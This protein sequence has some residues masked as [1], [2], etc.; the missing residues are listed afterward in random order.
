MRRKIVKS[1]YLDTGQGKNS[2]IVCEGKLM[3]HL[4]C[5]SVFFMSLAKSQT[6]V[7]ERRNMERDY[8][9]EEELLK[10]YMPFAEQTARYYIHANSDVSGLEWEDIAQEAYIALLSAIRTYQA[11]K[12]ASFET[13]ANTLIRNRL[14]SY[15]NRHKKKAGQVSL[16]YIS[17]T[18]GDV[19][20]RR[21]PCNMTIHRSFKDTTIFESFEDKVV[22]GVVYQNIW[23]L[24]TAH[25]DMKEEKYKIGLFAL[26]EKMNGIKFSVTAQNLGI[27]YT[28]L[29]LCV[30]HTRNTLKKVPELKEFLTT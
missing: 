19:V 2:M 18:S 8:K 23:D 5:T 28:E 13:Y 21:V 20:Y 3:K 6:T 12:G 11:E 9:K 26:T 22:S 16:E 15:A 17:E 30:K 4:M 14:F 25:L 1:I 29:N 10:Q 7:K 27:T 24:I